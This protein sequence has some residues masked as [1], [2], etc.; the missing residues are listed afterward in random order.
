METCIKEKIKDEWND[1]RRTMIEKK[2]SI[3]ERV[4][5]RGKFHEKIIWFK[6]YMVSCVW[7]VQR[8]EK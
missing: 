3:R 8:G 2:D 5:K 4:A 1:R 6:S 7:R